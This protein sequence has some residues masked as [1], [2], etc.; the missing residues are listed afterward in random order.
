MQELLEMGHTDGIYHIQG[1][2]YVKYNGPH[3]TAHHHH[4]AWCCKANDKTNPPRLETKKGELYS[5]TFKCLNCKGDH[6]ADSN[7]YS[8]W[9][10]HFNKEWHTKE[11]SKL[12]ETRKNLTC[13]AMITF[14]REPDMMNNYLIV[15]MFIIIRLS[16]FHF[17][18]RKDVINHR[19]ILLTSF[20]N[21][22]DI[23]WL[24]NIYSDS[25][26]SVIKY[27]KDTEFNIQNLLVITGDFNI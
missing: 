4:F 14:I 13:L 26:H 1:A 8:F 11:Y 10:H 15:T 3:L 17:F 16:S 19:D 2:K 27:L 5:H 21:N 23:F 12:W 22:G 20:F 18:F 25:S 6:Q 9:K 7:E 24:T